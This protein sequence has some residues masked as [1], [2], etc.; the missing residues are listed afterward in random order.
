[1]SK[2][3]KSIYRHLVKGLCQESLN[4][5]ELLKGGTLKGD[6]AFAFQFIDTITDEQKNFSAIKAPWMSKM[7]LAVQH[8]FPELAQLIPTWNESTK[9]LKMPLRHLFL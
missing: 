4:E 1:M 6:R 3:L 7:L 8:D 9:K 5:A 2:S